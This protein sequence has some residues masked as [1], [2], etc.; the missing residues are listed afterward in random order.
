MT[1]EDVTLLHSYNMVFVNGTFELPAW[2]EEPVKRRPPHERID[3][4]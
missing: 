1:S 2:S 3:K 4:K